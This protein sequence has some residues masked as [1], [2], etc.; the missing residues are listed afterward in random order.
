MTGHDEPERTALVPAP[1]HNLHEAIGALLQAHDQ[2][3]AIS[4]VRRLYRRLEEARQSGISY[5]KLSEAMN[6]AGVR[7]TPNTLTKSMARIRKE[8]ARDKGRADDVLPA[9]SPVVVT[10]DP[11]QG[12]AV[13]PPPQN[14]SLASVLDLSLSTEARHQAIGKNYFEAGDNSRIAMAI[15]RR[16]QAP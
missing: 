16:K 14:T 9:A 7:M 3:S 8:R 13:N 10:S 2:Q 12:A 1:S 5:I 15:K 6:A 4:H 11:S